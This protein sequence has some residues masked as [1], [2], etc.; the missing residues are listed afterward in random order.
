MALADTVAEAINQAELAAHAIEIRTNEVP[1]WKP[2]WMRE[3]HV[4]S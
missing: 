4:I 3:K 2:Q 1:E